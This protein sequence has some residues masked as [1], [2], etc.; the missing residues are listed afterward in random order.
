MSSNHHDGHAGSQRL[1]AATGSSPGPHACL[2]ID[3][4]LVILALSQQAAATLQSFR[5]KFVGLP[6]ALGPSCCLSLAAGAHGNPHGVAWWLPGFSRV[7]QAVGCQFERLS[8]REHSQGPALDR[9]STGAAM[10]GAAAVSAA[11]MLGGM[12]FKCARL[13]LPPA[14]AIVCRALSCGMPFLLNFARPHAH[15]VSLSHGCLQTRCNKGTP[16]D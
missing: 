2:Q 11:A 3:V 7:V 1:P 13:P 9:E 12:A 15:P 6:G 14:R 16:F 5:Q 4:A 10:E 8:S